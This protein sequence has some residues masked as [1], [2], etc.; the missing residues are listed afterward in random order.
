VRASLAAIA[1]AA[2]LIGL[3][4]Q[5]TAAEAESAAED[6]ELTEV[7]VTGTRIRNPNIT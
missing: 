2:S 6:V 1:A 5:A 3:S 7:Q 4:W